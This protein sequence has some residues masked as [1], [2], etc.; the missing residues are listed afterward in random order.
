LVKKIKLVLLFLCLALQGCSVT[1]LA[2]ENADTLLRWQANSYF[3]FE[4]EQ[5]EELDR[6]LMAFL[7]W[8]RAK[9]LPQYARLAE[10]ASA[11]LRRGLKREDLEWG[12]DS[13]KAQVRETLGAAAAE[14]AALL[15]RLS[16]GQITHLEQRLA[17]ENRKFA[18][19]LM[20][21]TVEERHVRR[22][23]RNVERLEEWFGALDEA[24]VERVRR[25]S[26]R[27]PFSAELRDRDR[28]RRQGELVAMLRAREAKQRLVPWVQAWDQGREPAYASA[29]RE[30]EAEYFDL[31]LDLDRL[32]TPAQREACAARLQRYAALFDSLPRR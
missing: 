23:K 21:G 17:E 3:D 5:S 29:A 11:R 15:D 6:R 32:L 14:S 20:Q 28:K 27:A 26:A 2:Y 18:K 16:P 31:L 10:D 25:Y 8:H 13:V 22:V 12:Y 19:E 30:T 1:R 7:A 9:A 4:G 24:Q